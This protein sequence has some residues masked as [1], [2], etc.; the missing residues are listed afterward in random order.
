MIDFKT[1]TE[2]IVL[3]K[4]GIVH[5]TVLKGAYMDLS[6]AKEN[7]EPIKMLSKG[8]KVSVLVDIRKLKGC[9]QKSRAYFANNEA[10]EIQSASPKIDI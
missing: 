6:D 7:L 5:C 3:E 9:S 4:D 1:K 10:E 2:H 8:K